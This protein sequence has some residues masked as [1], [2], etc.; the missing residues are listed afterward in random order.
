MPKF[1]ATPLAMTQS[2]FQETFGYG[3][4]GTP[5]DYVERQ[6]IAVEAETLTDVLNKTWDTFQNVE[7]PHVCPDG[8]RS[9]MVGDIIRVSNEHGEDVV[10]RRVASFGFE[11]VRS[12]KTIFPR[13]TDALN[14]KYDDVSYAEIASEQADVDA[15]E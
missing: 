5:Q 4:V 6:T 11:E 3:E 10:L 13:A 8:G 12:L 7:H 15:S 9:L 2:F 14:G 1:L